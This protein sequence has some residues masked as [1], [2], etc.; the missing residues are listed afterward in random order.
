MPISRRSFIA[1]SALPALQT[2]STSRE[3]G[4]PPNVLF[5]ISDQHKPG[6]MGIDG[7]KQART[8]ALDGL[9]QSGVR[10][11]QA[12]CANPIC[13]PARASLWTGLYTHH[14]GVVANELP[15]PAGV[16]SIADVLRSA[17]Y[18]TAGIGKM[19]FA[20]AQ[21]HGFDYRLDFNDWYQYLGPKSKLYADEVGRAFPGD[22][23]PQIGS[24]WRDSGDPWKDVYEHDGR[25]GSTHLGRPSKMAERDHFETFVARESIEYLRS[26]A[27]KGP[28]FLVASFLKPHQPFMPAARFAAMYRPE[29]MRLPDSWGKLDP[30]TMPRFQMASATSNRLTPELLDPHLAVQRLASYYGSLAQTDDCLGQVLAALRDLELEDDTIVVYTSDH[31]EMLGEHSL[32]QKFVFFESSVGVPLI[33]RVPGVTAGGS[34]CEAPVSH[35]SLAPPWRSF[36]GSAP[37][38]PLTARVLSNFCIN[39]N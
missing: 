19:H 20:N 1:S 38:R 29:D 7:H 25:K 5:L 21:T 32:W 34:I 9:A 14:H 33:L 8:P 28:F 24:L 11:R 6:V 36:T 2:S 26:H 13:G 35:V 15:W 3:Q 18:R 31:G 12:Y 22:G 27:R 23:H 17:G 37:T 10:F 4:R 30:A 16:N 39:R